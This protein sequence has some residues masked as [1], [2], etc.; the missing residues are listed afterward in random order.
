MKRHHLAAIAAALAATS[1]VT[2]TQAQVGEQINKDISNNISLDAGLLNG[3]PPEDEHV[4]M[5]YLRTY[6]PAQLA[7]GTAAPD[8]E[9]RNIL[10]NLE[11]TRAQA[12][13]LISVFN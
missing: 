13:P 9:Y 5:K 11:K 7:D 3:V 10:G 4:F 1:A 2:P 12:K 8:V 6:V